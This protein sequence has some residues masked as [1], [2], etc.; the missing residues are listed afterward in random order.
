MNLSSRP[1]A[2]CLVLGPTDP[3]DPSP[4]LPHSSPRDDQRYLINSM[5]TGGCSVCRPQQRR[6]RAGH[7]Q[8]VVQAALRAQIRAA[9]I[10]M[11]PPG[12]SQDQKHRYQY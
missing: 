8:N 9:E 11:M 3:P 5:T 4:K 1:F 2:S 10:I 12:L 7:Y 6:R